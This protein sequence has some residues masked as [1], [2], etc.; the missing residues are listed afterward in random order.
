MT[1]D[2]KE[3]VRR[4]GDGVDAAID[5]EF[6]ELR[7]IARRLPAQTHFGT[8]RVGACDDAPDH[9]PHRLVLLVE[10]AGELFRVAVHAER[11]LC[12][13]VAADREPIEARW[14]NRPPG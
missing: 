4:D 5:E 13:V 8:R 3:T 12:Q 2:R 9:P 6:R 14:R 7:V 10:E 1:L 11:E